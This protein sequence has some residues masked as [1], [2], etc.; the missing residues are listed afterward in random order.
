MRRGKITGACDKLVTWYKPKN[1]PQGLAESEFAALPQSFTV[2]E[3]YYYIIIPG[4]RT[5]RVSLITT[6][7]DTKTYSTLKLVELYGKRW[8]VELDFKYLKTTLEM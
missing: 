4:F 2:R 8:N 3:I 7:L 6:L 1:C 5:E